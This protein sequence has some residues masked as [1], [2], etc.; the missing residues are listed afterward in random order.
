[1]PQKSTWLDR[2][3]MAISPRAGYDRLRYR[4]AAR[5][6]QNYD[7][8]GTGRRSRSW[9]PTATDADAAAARRL[10]L[11][12]VSRDM[13]RNTP[14]AVRARSCITNNVVGTGIKPSFEGSE[15]TVGTAKELL[16]AHLTALLA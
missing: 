16:R 6:I 9:N 12:F 7:A 14:Y 2:A 8:A 10:R 3:V 1:M 5:V 11:A 13:I 15:A 4:N